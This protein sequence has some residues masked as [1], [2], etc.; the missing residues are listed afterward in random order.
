MPNNKFVVDDA[1]FLGDH[2]LFDC[3]FYEFALLHAMSGTQKES[4]P[5]GAFKHLSNKGCH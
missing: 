4:D 2:S 1:Q 3:E 5:I